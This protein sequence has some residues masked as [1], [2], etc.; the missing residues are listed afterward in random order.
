MSKGSV[1]PSGIKD[2]ALFINSV[3]DLMAMNNISLKNALSQVLIQ[4][5][6]S[7]RVLEPKECKALFDLYYATINDDDFFNSVIPI[8]RELIKNV[9]STP[10]SEKHLKQIVIRK[11]AE[12]YNIRVDNISGLNNFSFSGLVA[13]KELFFKNLKLI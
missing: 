3:S 1:L 13:L 6:E 12:K 2:R 4:K 9:V 8:H 10:T 5:L 7:E 11:F